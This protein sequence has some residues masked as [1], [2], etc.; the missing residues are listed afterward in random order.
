MHTRHRIVTNRFFYATGLAQLLLS[1][2]I[3]TM[4][5][6]ARGSVLFLLVGD[7]GTFVVSL[8]LTLLVRYQTVPSKP[9]L[10]AHLFA[11]GVLFAVWVLTFFIAGLYDRYISLARK[12]IPSLVWKAQCF[13]M[14]FAGIIFFTVPFGIEPKTNLVIYL[15]ISSLLVVCWRLY[16][17]PLF[18]AGSFI[19]AIIIGDSAEAKSVASLFAQSPFYQHIKTTILSKEQLSNF[20]EYAHTIATYIE[21]GRTEMVIADM[22]DPFAKALSSQFYRIAFEDRNVR[23]FKL[24]AIYEQLL[25]RLPPSLINEGW[26]LEN[27]SPDAPHYA[28]D[29]LKRTIDIIG[30]VILSIPTLFLLPF[31]ALAIK[32]EDNG[33][34]FYKAIRV[35]EFGNRIAMFKFR[36]MNGSDNA[37]DALKSTLQVTRVGA[38]LRKTRLDELPQLYNILT[39]ELSFIGPRPEI[40]SL[41]EVY[42]KNIPYYQLRHLMKPG[43]SGWAQ[44]N[45]F[46][47]PKGGVDIEKTIDK[48]SFDLYYLKHRSFMLDLEIALKTINTLLSRTG[49]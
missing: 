22:N 34:L 1:R 2:M 46:D 5:K 47:V 8:I 15:I 40:P 26:L 35:G 39:G 32:L 23:F 25:H 11:F 6:I 37:K 18:T 44:I 28:Y 4:E 20:D 7:V 19:H 45:N 49:T 27:I 41:V 16:L 14:L 30:A 12:N 9:I 10:Y 17:F 24:S 43:L 48:L 3:A 13:N 29:A 38:F 21:D 36:T 42:A 31:I 33:P